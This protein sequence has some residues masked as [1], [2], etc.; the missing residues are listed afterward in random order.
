MNSWYCYNI[1]CI[2]F[3]LHWQRNFDIQLEHFQCKFSPSHLI[4]TCDMTPATSLNQSATLSFEI[5]DIHDQLDSVQLAI[6]VSAISTRN[7]SIV[8]QLFEQTID[9]CAFFLHP[10]KWALVRVM[11]RDL[12][13]FGQLPKRCPIE[14]V[15]FKTV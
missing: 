1:S 6:N 9:I 5:T 8:I 15:W 12:R 11:N 14:K 3:L 13:K 4:G 7:E 10:H 2:V